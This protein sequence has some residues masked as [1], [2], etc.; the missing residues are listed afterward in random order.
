M[1]QWKNVLVMVLTEMRSTIE[2]YVL[3]YTQN[4]GGVDFLVR[5]SKV[6]ELVG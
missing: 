2:Y 4:F 1:V 6:R 3:R 5:E